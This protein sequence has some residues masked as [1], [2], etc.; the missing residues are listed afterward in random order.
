MTI[1]NRTEVR[2]G[3]RNCTVRRSVIASL[4]NQVGKIRTCIALLS[5]LGISMMDSCLDPYS[6]PAALSQVNYLVVEGFLNDVSSPTVIRLS[7]TI[8]LA[9]GERRVPEPNAIVE[10]QDDQGGVFALTETDPG[11]YSL[12]SLIINMDRNYRLKIRTSNNKEYMSDFVPFKQTPVIDSVNW[13]V[14]GNHLYI[15]ANAHDDNNDTHYYFWNFDET[16]AYHSAFPSINKFENGQIIDRDDDIY[17]CWKTLSSTQ[18]QISTSV[19]LAQ[20]IISN[21]TLV[22]MPLTSEKLQ[23]EY[24]LM[25]H[26]LALTKD[27][28]EYW[29]QLKKNTENIGTIFGPQPSQILSNIHCTSNPEEPVIGYFSACSIE[30]KRVFIFRQDLPITR[31]VTGYEDCVQDTLFNAQIPD[32]R[33]GELITY[34]ISVGMPPVVIGYFRSSFF[35]VDC[36]FHGGTTVKPDF[37][38]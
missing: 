16:W 31:N 15:Y 3:D 20:D 22:I 7:R 9:S 21:Y 23:T 14:D 34:P 32:F 37:W 33:G 1:I 12:F 30:Q 29:Q 38:K 11:S 26:Q 17:H 4:H 8:P 36:R 35:C 2:A 5:M 27:A 24:S 10:I 6:I 25:L 18:I 13:S 19:K 28:F